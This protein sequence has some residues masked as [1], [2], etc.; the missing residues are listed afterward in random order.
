M[1]FALCCV[2]SLYS[3][4]LVA[5]TLSDVFSAQSAC[6]NCYQR[7]GAFAGGVGP[8]GEAS[9]ANNRYINVGFVNDPNDPAR[10]EGDAAT[11]ISQ[12][13][14]TAAN[15]WNTRTGENSNE[16]IPFNIQASQNPSR[17]NIVLLQVDEVPGRREPGDPPA[18]A[19]IGVR[20]DANGNVTSPVAVYM[21]RDLV[22]TLSAD[23]LAR[24][25]EHELGHFMGLADTDRSRAGQCDTIM[26]RARGN[27]VPRVGITAGDVTV[28]NRYVNNNQQ[29][30]RLRSGGIELLE[31][32]GYTDPTPIPYYPPTCYYYYDAVDVYEFC[33][34][35]ESGSPRGYRYVGTIY[36]LTDVFCTY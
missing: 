4:G 13:I 8:N 33:D 36:Y 35:N 15:T 31:P 11:R 20:R 5:Y 12:A 23:Q 2:L 14:N 21:R 22:Q 26:D 1:K 28:V 27:C 19:G 3:L 29:C 32:P 9:T 7:E 34:C 16:R 30:R 18:C 24:I 10:F 17:I 25:I 6:T